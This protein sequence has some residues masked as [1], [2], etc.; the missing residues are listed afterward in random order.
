MRVF[1]SA[2][3]LSIACSA[4][5]TTEDTTIFAPE[6]QP[7]EVAGCECPAGSLCFDPIKVEA[8]ALPNRARVA[9]VWQQISQADPDP[10]G[11]IA[12]DAPFAKGEAIVVPLYSIDPPE[13]D[14]LVMCEREC[15]DLEACPCI[16]EDR[17]AFGQ[18][19][20]TADT[21]GNGRVDMEELRS[22]SGRGHF[23]IGR[24]ETKMD[25]V[26]SS[27]GGVVFGHLIPQGIRAYDFVAE[28]DRV[29]VAPTKRAD[30]QRVY[31]CPAG[32]ETCQLP[33]PQIARQAH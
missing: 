12:Y 31:L 13:R 10:L 1:P 15:A 26:P 33:F 11:Q 29:R 30:S 16:G 18:V 6:G 23:V 28:A 8:G 22:P 19:F 17:V 25:P 32:S 24:S 27:F 3:L 7:I 14:A 21:N 4:C 5:A 9:V 20:V 2:V